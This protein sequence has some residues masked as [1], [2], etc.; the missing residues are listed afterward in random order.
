MAKKTSR[1]VSKGSASS[2]GAVSSS[3]ASTTRTTLS[4]RYAET[5]VTPDYS[6]VRKDLKRVGI[7]AGS[8]FGA[9]IILYFILPY[10][11][12]LYAH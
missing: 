5:V 9:M 8:M 11:L 6:Y 4:S 7:L 2:S 10:I 1:Q 12:P 3:P